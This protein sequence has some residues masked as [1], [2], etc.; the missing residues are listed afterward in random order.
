MDLL[1]GVYDWCIKGTTIL[2]FPQFAK[3]YLQNES[4]L[5]YLGKFI[6]VNPD[7]AHIEQKLYKMAQEFQFSV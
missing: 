7:E 5:N 4:P 2:Q 1:D 3:N 6:L